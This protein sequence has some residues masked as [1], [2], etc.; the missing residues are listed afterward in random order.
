MQVPH[1]IE[2]QK[3]GDSEI[4]YI[5]VAQA[6]SNVPFEI[7]RVYWTYNTP[8][9]V[10]RGNHAHRNSLQLIVCLT[11]KMS[12]SLEDRK[13]NRYEFIL[14]DPSKGLLMPHYYWRKIKFFDNSISICM[15]S[16]EFDEEDYIRDYQTF[17]NS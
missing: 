5:S 4:G 15:S 7:K 14:D 6:F 9:S 2:L 10:E 12:V 3:I 11:G 13:G 17:L 1:L 8:E 16:L